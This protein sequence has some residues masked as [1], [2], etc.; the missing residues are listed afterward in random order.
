MKTLILSCNTGQGHNSAGKALLEEFTRRGL[1]CEMADALSFGAPHASDYVSGSYIHI[2]QRAPRVFGGIYRIGEVL[3]SPNRK[4]PVYFANIRYA[5][6]LARHIAQNEFDTVLSP[7]LF[8]AEALTFLRRRRGL[9]VRSYG[10]ATDYT[11][12]PFWEETDIDCFFIPHADMLSE[13]EGKG[14]APKR[15]TVTGI[16]VSSA[17]RLRTPAPEARR[18]LG[19]PVEGRVYLVMTGSM[20]AG[21]VAGIVSELLKRMAA[22]DHAVVMEG[23]NARLS[24]LLK[25]RFGG[26]ERVIR[27]PF[28]PRV[29]LYMDACDV[30]L[31]KPGGLSSTEAAVK[32]VPLVHTAPIPGC[33]TVNARFFGEHGLS[34]PTRTPSESAAAAVQLAGDIAAQRRM[35]AA[36]QA[37]IRS[38]A[39]AAI[40]DRLL[41]A[42]KEEP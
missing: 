28:T 10:V 6:A 17:F 16:P 30:L 2:T 5:E 20:G 41:A 26:D 31:T 18:T 3:S 12:S 1:P 33:E 39:A 11:C 27:V 40:C 32:N 4:S 7:H 36:Q 9:T 35:A 42:A 8:P 22:D 34:V 14:F 15:L 19:L 13:Y 23:G 24:A 37:Q 21:D 29:P 38:D 25:E